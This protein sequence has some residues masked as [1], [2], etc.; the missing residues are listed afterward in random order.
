[1]KVVE[2]VRHCREEK[3]SKSTSNL[4]IDLLELRFFDIQL[5]HAHAVHCIIFNHQNTVGQTV[6]AAH[7]KTSVIGLEDDFS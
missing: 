6:Y 2:A 3:G 7:A 5:V 4:V 1:M